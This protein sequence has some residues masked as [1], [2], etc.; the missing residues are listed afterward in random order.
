M[1]DRTVFLINLVSFAYETPLKG[2]GSFI[3]LKSSI[4]LR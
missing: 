1:E 2:N 3:S 4:L